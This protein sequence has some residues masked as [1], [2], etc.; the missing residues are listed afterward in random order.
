V[1]LRRTHVGPFSVEDAD[2]EKIIEPDA[3]LAVLER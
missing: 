3:A 1:S 2:P